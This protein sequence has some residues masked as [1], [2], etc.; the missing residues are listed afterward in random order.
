[1]KARDHD[2]PLE[3]FLRYKEPASTENFDAFAGEFISPE[4]TVVLS[5]TKQG[6]YYVLLRH[7]SSS[8]I[9]EIAITAKLAEFEITNVYP[10]TASPHKLHNTFTITGSFFPSD[11]SIMLFPKTNKS[12]KIVPLY[13][14]RSSSTLL[15]LTAEMFHFKY[16]D[17]ITVQIID[18]ISGQ[19]T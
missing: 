12:L 11:L 7:H 2:I 19:T 18:D 5:N 13:I 14:Y 15:F 10:K 4:Q 17:V 9:V 1:M 6:N 3:I 8:S 16:G